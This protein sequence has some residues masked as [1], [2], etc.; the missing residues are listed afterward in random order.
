MCRCRCAPALPVV[1]H[2]AVAVP[3]PHPRA[4]CR[5]VLWPQYVRVFQ[6]G[7]SQGAVVAVPGAIVSMV[8]EGPLLA[9]V[10]HRQ[11][12]GADRQFMTTS[13]WRIGSD[14]SACQVCVSDVPLP[15]GTD[16]A[17]IGFSTN[18]VS[19]SRSLFHSG[20]CCFS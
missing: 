10:Y 12:A 11:A 8:G 20:C 18:H 9:V 16:L 7:G 17:W 2:F 1:T 13:L 6:A 14:G 3:C 15:E 19:A 4:S 5:I